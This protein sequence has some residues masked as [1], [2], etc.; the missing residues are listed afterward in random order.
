MSFSLPLKSGINVSI[1][2]LG[3]C[4]LISFIVSTQILAPP[5]GKS[6]RSTDVI[7]A[8]LTFMRLIDFA[9]FLGSSVS[10][11]SG[12]PVITLQKPQERV[13]I[14]PKIIKVAVP[15]PQ[16]SPMFGQLPLSQIVCRL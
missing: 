11:A 13:Q 7:T 5:S 15:A 1:V 8:C 2:V 9:T 12:L 6:S 4:L 10:T 3:F 14:F 16:H